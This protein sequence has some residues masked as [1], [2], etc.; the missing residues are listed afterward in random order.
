LK[1]PADTMKERNAELGLK[2]LNLP[3]RRRLAEAEPGT[4]ATEPAAVGRR[5]EHPQGA[6]VHRDKSALCI[7]SR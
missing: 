3:R 5:H 2:G 4:R 6:Q 1:L 7:D